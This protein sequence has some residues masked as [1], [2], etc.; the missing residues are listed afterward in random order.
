MSSYR[1]TGTS[2]GNSSAGETLGDHSPTSVG[3][4]SPGGAAAGGRSADRL[5]RDRLEFGAAAQDPFIFDNGATN[6][7]NDMTIGPSVHPSSFTTPT[8]HGRSKYNEDNCIRINVAKSDTKH[9]YHFVA[10][11]V[12]SLDTEKFAI[13]SLKI[14]CS[15]AD[16]VEVEISEDGRYATLN[17]TTPPIGENVMALL[18]EEIPAKHRNL[19]F[20]ATKKA[21]NNL[22]SRAE[23][24]ITHK[25]VLKLPFRSHPA[26]SSDLLGQGTGQNVS[27]QTIAKHSGRNE[28]TANLVLVFKE[29]EDGFKAS[30]TVEVAGSYCG[31]KMGE[32]CPESAREMEAERRSEAQQRRRDRNR[33]RQDGNGQSVNQESNGQQVSQAAI[34]I[35]EIAADDGTGDASMNTPQTIG[36]VR[37]LSETADNGNIQSSSRSRTRRSGQDETASASSA[38]VLRDNLQGAGI[39]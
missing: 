26:P 32:W 29:L 11:D 19:L 39:F 36:H 31:M 9:F 22:K 10:P 25:L 6:L 27:I 3:M 2:P 16:S 34:D 38:S 7:L 30:S 17:I 35:A 21:L 4:D 33:N 23:D 15:Y 1:D 37:T 5:Y 24:K 8:N 13:C 28:M 20:N 12:I 14:P 18:G